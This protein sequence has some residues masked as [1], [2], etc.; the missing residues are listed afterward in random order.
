METILDWGVGIVLWFQMSSPSLDLP[1]KIITFMGNE[2]FFI[3]ILPFIYWCVDRR[4]G[5]RLSILFLFSAYINSAAKVFA[6]QPR[7]F[8]YDARV[9]QIVST[10]GGGLPS[11]HT[12]GALVF[13]GYLASC[14]KRPLLWVIAGLLVRAILLLLY[15][16]L[17]PRVETWLVK[18][19][20]IWQ[21]C[22][23]LVMPSLMIFFCPGEGK[24]G[25]GSAATLMGMGIGFI[26][27][28]L[29]V[30]FECPRFWR[31][32]ILCFV[33]GMGVLL[34][35]RLGL[36]AC[37]SGLEPEPFF[38]FV[39]YSLMGLWCGFGAPWTFLKLGMIDKKQGATGGRGFF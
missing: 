5:V 39:R 28:R 30:G 6:S 23:A 16:W 11:G 3:L 15:L 7:P 36:Y 38:R 26:F 10:G 21:I 14:F 2:G 22:A 33:L 27:E 9:K 20:I 34:L 29:S 4:T 35:L 1:F 13:W 37:L 19:G 8:Q 32:R 24:Y 17:E 31:K 12:Q 25:I 18:K